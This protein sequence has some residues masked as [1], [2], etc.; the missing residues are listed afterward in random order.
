[1]KRFLLLR[2]VKISEAKL[3]KNALT[4][5]YLSFK[6]V[7]KM[8]DFGTEQFDSSNAQV[9]CDNLNRKKRTF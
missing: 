9:F 8:N 3:N 4:H 5:S 2:F 1:M 7:L 6:S